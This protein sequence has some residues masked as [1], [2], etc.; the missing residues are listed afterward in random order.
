MTPLPPAVMLAIALTTAA[1]VVGMLI[2]LLVQRA[3]RHR[4]QRR[5]ERLDRRLRPLV[6]LGTV[7]EDDEIESLLARVRALG[8]DEQRHVRRTVFHMLR[9]VTGEAADRLRLIGDAAGITERVFAAS[10][11]RSVSLRADAAEGLGLLRP[12]GALEL[13]CRLAGDRSPVVRTVAVR[14]LGAYT[15]TVAVDIAVSALAA[16]SEVPNSVAASAL[17]D[18]GL[19]ASDRVREA[20][21]D[22][23]AGVRHGAARV[24]GLLQVPGSSDT[25][26]RLI[27]DPHPSVRLAAV[28]SLRR[29]P[30]RSAVPGLLSLA[31]ADAGEGEAAARTLAAM[32][33]AWTADAMARLDSDGSPAVR[34]AAELPRRETTA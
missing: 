23:D 21:T 15:D 24:A 3:V 4:S 7:A 28:R 6:L 1:V 31:L 5:R 17:L 32:P 20:L 8:D 14:A 9:D 25:L 12:P 19:A 26:A 18:Q 2:S 33:A 11:D 10:R 13:L 27:H 30:A 22:E 29:L 34:R 16:G